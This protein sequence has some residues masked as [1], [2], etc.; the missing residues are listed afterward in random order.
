MMKLGL[1]C[2]RSLPGHVVS[3]AS[4]WA[5]RFKVQGSKLRKEKIPDLPKKSFDSASLIKEET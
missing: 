4:G 1:A 5:D 3:P 2:G